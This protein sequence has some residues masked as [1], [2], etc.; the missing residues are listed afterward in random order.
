MKRLLWLAVVCLMVVAFLVGGC[1]MGLQSIRPD[2]S[3]EKI[4]AKVMRA[5]EGCEVNAEGWKILEIP[6][7]AYA[8]NHIKFIAFRSTL[9]DAWGVGMLNEAQGMSILLQHSAK[10]G[11]VAVQFG[12]PMPMEDDKAIQFLHEWAQIVAENGDFTKAGTFK[13]CEPKETDI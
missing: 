8:E 13:P 6:D 12:F 10:L 1:A 9:E 4:V 11:W 7:K 3:P 2:T 5:V